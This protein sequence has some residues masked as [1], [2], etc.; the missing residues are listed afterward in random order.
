MNF[1]GLPT[2]IPKN[3]SD[4]GRNFIFV[5][6]DENERLLITFFKK[7]FLFPKDLLYL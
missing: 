6:E 1:S 4:H 2:S 5:L 7:I 3:D